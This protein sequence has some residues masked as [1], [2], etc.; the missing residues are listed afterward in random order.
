MHAALGHRFP[1]ARLVQRFSLL[2]DMQI[3]HGG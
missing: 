3:L 2:K 1:P